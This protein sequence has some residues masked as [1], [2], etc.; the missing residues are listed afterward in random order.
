MH[1]GAGI[2]CT[3]L[4]LADAVDFAATRCKQAFIEH[5]GVAPDVTLSGDTHLTIPYVPAH[6]DY[7]L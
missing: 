2:V 1:P 6:L 4:N 7:M 5:Y 3:Q